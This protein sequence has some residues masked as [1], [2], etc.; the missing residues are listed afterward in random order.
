VRHEDESTAKREGN[1]AVVPKTAALDQ[2]QQILAQ[3][4]DA[5]G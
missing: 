4:F 3:V 1:R 2:L 5:T